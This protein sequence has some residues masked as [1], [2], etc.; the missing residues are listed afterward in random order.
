MKMKAFED[1]RTVEILSYASLRVLLNL[2]SADDSIAFLSQNKELME[3]IYNVVAD[4][5][6]VDLLTH[7]ETIKMTS[8]YKE[9]KS[10]YQE[11][12][13]NITD[14]YSDLDLNDPLS[15][16]AAYQYMYRS[17]FL[18][19]GKKFTYS[20]D[21]KDLTDL[22]GLDVIRGTGV[23][24]SISSMLIDIYREL[25]YESHA[26]G[27]RV[28]EGMLNKVKPNLDI[29][30]DATKS[31][32]KFLKAVV[33]ISTLFHL[34]NHAITEVSSDKGKILLCPTNCL[35]L[36]KHSFKI[37]VADQP[38]KKAMWFNPFSDLVGGLQSNPINTVSECFSTYRAPENHQEIMARVAEWCK[39]NDEVFEYFYEQN[40]ELFG[41]IGTLGDEKS[42]YIKRLLPIFK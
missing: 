6:L 12:I 1:F 14:F 34:G 33:I 16:C 27:V 26:L 37:T 18:S 7:R 38:T 42:S 31:S 40:K 13:H 9:L 15:V 39:M 5:Y 28:Q 23:C 2:A 11:S 10:L 22:L 30:I 20:N 3:Y 25:G 8:D 41:D 21:M 36:E 24:R 35:V 32:R 29:K 17:G 4:V 19:R